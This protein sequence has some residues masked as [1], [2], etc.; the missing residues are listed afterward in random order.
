[1]TGKGV[2]F[3]EVLFEF[4]RIGQAVRVVAIDPASGTEVTMVGDARYGI[5]SL[6]RAAARKLAYVIGKRRDE[7]GGAA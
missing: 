6:K 3:S 5:E 4:Q 7:R 2:P 1:M